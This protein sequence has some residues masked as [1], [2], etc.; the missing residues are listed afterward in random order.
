MKTIQSFRKYIPVLGL[1]VVFSTN[2]LISISQGKTKEKKSGRNEIR[3]EYQPEH[4]ENKKEKTAYREEDKR[5]HYYNY[6]EYQPMYQRKGKE[7][8]P[9]SYQHHDYGR[10]YNR[11]DHSPVTFKHSKGNYHYIDNRFYIYRKGIGY[12]YIEPPRNVYFRELPFMC[13][14]VY[15]NGTVYYRNGDLFFR[16]TRNGYILVPSPFEVRF[17]VRF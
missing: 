3:K 12:C 15:A 9:N 5:T 4:R 1:F 10:V 6:K 7:S 14:R 11:F 2:P 17:S 16:L 13:S 8:I